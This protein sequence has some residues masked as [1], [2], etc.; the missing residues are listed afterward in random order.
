MGLGISFGNFL[1]RGEARSLRL[2]FFR[3]HP[4]GKE[5]VVIFFFHRRLFTGGK[6][7]S[8]LSRLLGAIGCGDIGEHFPP[9]DAKW[10]NIDSREM[11]K[12]VNHLVKKKGATILNLDL[13]IICEKPKVSKYKE[14]MKEEMAKVLNILPSRVN[15]KATTTEKL[16]F[17]GR[18]EGIAA[19]A[20]AS[21]W[22][23]ITEE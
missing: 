2:V 22:M 14:R 21:L 17:L 20:V 18:E 13:T 8:C 19:Q 11:L 9:T 4:P 10:K 7:Y 12:I 23:V 6:R 1:L 5:N 15:I 3:P 16:G